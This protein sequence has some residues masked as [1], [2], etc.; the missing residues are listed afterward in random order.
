[1]HAVNNNYKT[2]IFT[3]I[4][5]LHQVPPS[6][7]QSKSPETAAVEVAD[8]LITAYSVPSPNTCTPVDELEEIIADATDVSAVILEEK[9]ASSSAKSKYGL[10]LDT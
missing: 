6:P 2:I 10:H 9:P 8:K 1:M 7:E 4:V 3:S 5:F